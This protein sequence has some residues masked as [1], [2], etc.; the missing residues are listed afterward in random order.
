MR[1]FYVI[2]VQHILIGLTVAVMLLG[3]A[4]SVQ[5][6]SEKAVAAPALM[7]RT[8]VIDPGHGGEDGGAVAADGTKESDIN[9]SIS[10]RLKELFLFCGIEPVMTREEDISVYTEGAV[11]LR[12]KKVSDIHN[13]VDQINALPDA[14]VLSIHQNSLPSSTKTHGAVV[15]YNPVDGADAYAAAIQNSLN[16]ACN[17]D[18]K[19]ERPIAKTIYLMQHIDKPAVLIECGFLSNPAEN[20]AL[21]TAEMQFRIALAILCGCFCEKEYP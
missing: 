6:M 1:R 9:L 19:Q 14:L 20:E 8:V 3:F 2:R 15:F 4:F 13:R 16:D 7:H 18:E 21:K 11:T 12:E 5:V 17:T 10:L